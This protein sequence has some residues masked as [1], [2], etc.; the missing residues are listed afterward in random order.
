MSRESTVPQR[1]AG[2]ARI[3]VLAASGA[4]VSLAAGV[5]A[6]RRRSRALA[7]DDE[8]RALTAPLGGDPIEVTS[9][10]GTR[11]H[12]RS[13]DPASE[14]GAGARATVVL[15]HGWTER[16]SLW[17]QVIAMLRGRGMRVVAY[18]LRGHGSSELA[19]DGD[20][21]I[22]RFG[23]DVDAVL[24]ATGTPASE[25]VIAGH[26]LGGMSVAAWAA[27]HDVR[28]RVAGA[29]IT[30]AGVDDLLGGALVFGALGRLLTQRRLGRAL[31]GASVPLPPLMTP[32]GQATIRYLAFGPS[33]TTAQVAFYERMLVQTPASVRAATGIALSDLDLRSA[34]A[35]LIVPT[36][37]IAGD[38]DRLTPPAH[39]ERIVAALPEPAGLIVLEQ[40]GHMSPLERPRQVADAITALAESLVRTPQTTGALV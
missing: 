37:V 1:S 14:P 28:E 6:Q 2:R 20:Y 33:A 5:A 17:G 7:R 18:D 16:L 15:A 24:R 35:R 3:T 36:V 30:N 10:D 34:L 9:A 39:S 4:A 25:T 31:V 21:S 22:E 11:L 19:A 27:H 26:S 38:H 13:F 32:V 40:T 12:A 29:L 8:Y 23:E